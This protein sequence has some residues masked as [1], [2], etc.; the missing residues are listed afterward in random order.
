MSSS[1]SSS[2]E[3]NPPP[4]SEP[5]P[6]A[7]TTD[8]LSGLCVCK[9]DGVYEPAGGLRI[10]A[11]V[12]STAR[13]G[14]CF[15]GSSRAPGVLIHAR[16]YTIA[17]SMI[18]EVKVVPSTTK[19]Q[20][21]VFLR[22]SSDTPGRVKDKD[23][24]FAS[25]LGDIRD[26]KTR[27]MSTAWCALVLRVNTSS[28]KD[29]EVVKSLLEVD[30]L[31]QAACKKAKLLQKEKEKEKAKEA[32][33]LTP[34]RPQI[35]DDDADESSSSSSSSSSDSSS[36]SSSGSESDHPVEREKRLIR[37]SAPPA[38]PVAHKSLPSSFKPPTSKPASS[39]SKLVSP[40]KHKRVV[41][42][43]SSEEVSRLKTELAKMKSKLKETEKDLETVKRHRDIHASMS[44][45]LSKRDRLNSVLERLDDEKRK[46]PR[47]SR[48]D[49]RTVVIDVSDD[50]QEEDLQ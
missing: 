2:H 39:S 18:E 44:R 41:S 33:V 34:T 50:E 42:L 27:F 26:S 22:R 9:P 7:L 15:D 28:L 4:P 5:Y 14:G 25:S 8:L 13:A 36:S 49:L 21:S 32:A 6:F 31:Y 48:D 43:K 46:I 47:F 29:P 11:R 35:E 24:W 45:L 30:D 23:G 3:F 17:R 1:S 16:G 10:N 19:N 40:P 38:R 20:L 12:L 37:S